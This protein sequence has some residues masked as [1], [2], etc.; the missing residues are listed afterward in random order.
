MTRRSIIAIFCLVAIIF[1][2]AALQTPLLKKARNWTWSTWVT[3]VARISSITLEESDQQR[4]EELL[5]ENIRLKSE[6]K[7]YSRLKKDLGEPAF[8][9][10]RTISATVV[11]RPIDTFRSEF[12]LSRG[13]HEGV[14]LGAPLITQ[15]STLIGFVT[16]LNDHSSVGR[17]LL[18]PATTLAVD[19]ID[20]T[21]SVDAISTS[22][23]VQG[24]SYTSLYLTTIPRDKPLHEGS[25]VITQSKAGLLPNGL[26]IGTV[27]TIHDQK[28][29]AY[30]EAIL[31]VPYSSD[32]LRAVNILVLP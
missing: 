12:V 9:D 18:H 27:K 29:A 19:V 3:S 21:L 1:F 20:P 31:D 8:Q 32:D 7:D 13:A 2:G 14:T 11:G 22:G 17:L 30:K 24:H 5:A 4:L 28:D 16:D 15:G 23:L 26:F 6:L 25:R 10:F